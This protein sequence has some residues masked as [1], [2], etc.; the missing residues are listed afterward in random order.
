[1]RM[2]DRAR[3]AGLI[4]PDVVPDDIRRLT[5]GLR[6]A[7]RSGDEDGATIDRYLEILLRGLRP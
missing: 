1:M 4:R 2:L 6:H 3:A 5:C 7:I